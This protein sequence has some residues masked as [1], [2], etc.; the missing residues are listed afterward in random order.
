VK[1]VICGE[2]DQVEGGLGCS[3]CIGVI[4]KQWSEAYPNR[5]TVEDLEWE[6]EHFP[7]WVKRDP[8]AGLLEICRRLMNEVQSRSLTPGGLEGDY[9]FQVYLVCRA[10][11]RRL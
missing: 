10:L 6:A 9:D 4:R 2:L 8:E 5:P 11:M 1:C 3:R 7:P